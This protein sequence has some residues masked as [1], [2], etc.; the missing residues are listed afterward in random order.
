MLA[1]IDSDFRVFVRGVLYLSGEFPNAYLYASVADGGFGVGASG[2]R[3]LYGDSRYLAALSSLQESSLRRSRCLIGTRREPLVWSHNGSWS[4]SPVI[5][6]TARLLS[7][8]LDLH[9]TNNY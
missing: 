6:C 3:F 7:G 8:V 9:V 1:Q 4:A 5:N 2:F